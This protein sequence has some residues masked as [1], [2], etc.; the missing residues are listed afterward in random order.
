MFAVIVSLLA[1]VFGL[2]ALLEGLV[3]I[4]TCRMRYPEQRMAWKKAELSP[5]FIYKCIEA[6]PVACSIMIAVSAPDSGL[7]GE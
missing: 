7:I 1:V 3:A 4:F 5:S 6:C 2:M